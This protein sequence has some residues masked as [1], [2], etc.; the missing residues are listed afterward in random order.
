VAPE[1]EELVW[2][3]RWAGR[4]SRGV[5]YAYPA[6]ERILRRHRVAHIHRSVVYAQVLGSLPDLLPWIFTLHGVGFEEH[7][8]HRPDMV[9]DIREYN[10][11][12]MRVIQAAPRSTVV[13]R[14]LQDYVK[15]RTGIAPPVTPPGIDLD[16]IARAGPEAFLRTSG[17]PPGYLLWVGRLAHEKG[18]DAFIGLAKRI[19]DRTFVVVTDRP[20]TEAFQEVKG[21]W[22]ANVRYLNGLPRPTVVSAFHACSIHVSTS[23]YES[24]S[25]TIPEAMA[26]G[27]PVVG[28]DL[29]GPRE[30]IQDSGGGYLYDPS[31]PDDLVRQVLAALDRPELGRKGQAYVREKR[32][33]KKLAAYF[34]RQYE[35][36][37]SEA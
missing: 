20:Q 26:C 18:L 22:P 15:E 34:D 21:P 23:L 2:G 11:V 3:L 35:E 10:E 37:A 27:K 17:L 32:D 14:W 5:P 8:A 29:F 28:P 25:T 30:I 12:A 33:W 16:E 13:A 9:Q 6:F 31:L 24:A 7:W 4:R 1:L 19:P 36:L